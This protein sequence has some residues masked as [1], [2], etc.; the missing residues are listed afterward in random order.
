M[1]WFLPPA[2]PKQERK[3][4]EGEKAENDSKVQIQF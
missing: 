1:P 3:G 4:R 2:S